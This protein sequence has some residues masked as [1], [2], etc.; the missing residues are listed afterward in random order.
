MHQNKDK[1]CNI[2]IKKDIIPP[3]HNGIN[4][5]KHPE[6]MSVKDEL[7]ACALTGKIS[8]NAIRHIKKLNLKNEVYECNIIGI[9]NFEK[10]TQPLTDWFNLFNSGIHRDQLYFSEAFAVALSYLHVLELGDIRSRQ[11]KFVRY[12]NHDTQLGIIRKF[13]R[14]VMPNLIA[15]YV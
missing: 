11:N 12:I 8:L 7:K 4:I 14:K 2:V 1:P 9:K 3:M 5:R 15:Y 10:C 13:N 6:S